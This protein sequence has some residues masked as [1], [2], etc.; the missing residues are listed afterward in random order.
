MATSTHFNIGTVILIC[1]LEI[2]VEDV[3]NADKYMG[4]R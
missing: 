3:K 2:K 1:L 4:P